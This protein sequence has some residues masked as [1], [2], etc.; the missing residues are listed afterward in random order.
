MRIIILAQVYAPEDVSGAVLVTELS[1]DLAKAGHHVSVVTCAPNYP[2]GRVFSEFKNRLFHK[3]WMGSV[4]VVRTWSFISPRKTF[5]R[6][7]MSYGSYSA[8]ALYGC[9]LLGRPDLIVSFS[10][11]LPLGISAWLLSRIWRVQWL[12]QIE[13]LFPDAAVASG[14]LNNQIAIRFFSAM[15]RFIYRHSLHISVISETFRQNLLGK[16]VRPD[17]L[18]LIPVWADPSLVYPLPKENRFRSRYGL[19]GKFVVMYAGNHGITSCLDVLLSAAV[20][21]KSD[22]E[23]SFVFIG[24]GIKKAQLKSRSQKFGLNNV[25]FLEY[26]SR[27]IFPEMMAAA[28]LNVVTLNTAS[29]LSSLPSKTF[30]IMASGRP[31]I[32]IAPLKSELAQLI[33]ETGCGLAV[34]PDEPDV[35]V[36]ALIELK[37]DPNRV[38]QMGR[39][40]RA[41]IEDRFS[42]SRCTKM[43]EKMLL[44]LNKQSWCGDGHG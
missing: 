41:L 21:L 15:E 37:D 20:R 9:L 12:L 34:S 16:G 22:S 25:L 40:G 42:R 44:N 33:E 23:I 35:F 27:K 29:F 32:A 30:N 43:F 26:Q 1:E 4:C 19:E 18:S 2:H 13:D 14:I 39:K 7:I 11:P 10:P 28:D 8:T 5:W 38:D 17:K 3:S 24:E 6:R 31:V 36:R